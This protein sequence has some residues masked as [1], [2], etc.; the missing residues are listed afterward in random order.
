MHLVRAVANADIARIRV[1]LGEER[2]LG[3]ARRAVALR[4]LAEVDARGAFDQLLLESGLRMERRDQFFDLVPRANDILPYE[5]AMRHKSGQLEVRFIVRPLSRIEIEY[6]DPHNAAP[7]PNHL[8][9]LLFESLT[10]RL[11]VGSHAPSNTF[12]EEHAK[13]TFNAQWAAVSVFDTDPEFTGGYRNGV[14]LALHRNDLADAYTLFLYDD[15]ELAGPLIDASLA[16][17]SFAP[18]VGKP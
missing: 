8:F 1:G 10:N 16:A 12:S 4:W 3:E 9:P 7:E 11:A 6:N 18:R 2:V 15:Y 5:H 13:K 17:L 14:L